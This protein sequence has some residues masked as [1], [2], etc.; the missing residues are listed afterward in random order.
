MRLVELH[1]RWVG[2]G[3]DGISDRDGNPAPL[4]KGVGVM[5][6]CPCGAGHEDPRCYV[7]FLNPLD[8]GPALELE[9]PNWT[10]TGETFETLTLAPS[11]HRIGACG[12]HGF[13]VDG[14][15]VVA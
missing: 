12:W 6:D 15:C 2:A 14:N 3:G 13:I 10:R 11:V 1:P 7:P 9:R 5:F 8:G 4:R